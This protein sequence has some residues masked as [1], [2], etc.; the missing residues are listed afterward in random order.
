[1]WMALLACASPGDS[2]VDTGVCEAA[3]AS[4]DAALATIQS[5]EGWSECGQVLVGTGCGCTR[6]QVVRTDADPTAFLAAWAAADEACGGSMS[7]G[8]DCPEAYGFDCVG[9]SC[10][11]DVS[12]GYYL[13]DCKAER[14]ADTSVTALA[15][16][17]GVLHVD[18]EYAGGCAD[19][20]F[21]LCW[22]DQ[23]FVPGDP[24]TVNLELFHD[25]NDESCEQAVAD[26]LDL[27]LG[28]VTVAWEEAYATSGGAMIL[29]LGGFSVEYDFE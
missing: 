29:S 3:E 4:R 16:E 28:M 10:G 15:A 24:P 6:N 22:P 8:C 2:A 27:S 1:M 13:P 12:D 14:G 18:V 21:T 17:E 26:T 25:A 20:T 5:C 19:H 11:W 23:T 9:N 7:S